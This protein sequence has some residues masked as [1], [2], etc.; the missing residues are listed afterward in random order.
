VRVDRRRSSGLSAFLRIRSAFSAVSFVN[1]G[2]TF[3]SLKEAISFAWRLPRRS[4]VS[5]GRT[6]SVLIRWIARHCA[7]QVVLQNSRP[8]TD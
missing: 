4:L 6:F 7:Q 8:S 2:P 1:A 3:L 5:L